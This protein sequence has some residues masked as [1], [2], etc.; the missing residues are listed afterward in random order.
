VWTVGTVASGNSA[1]LQ[2]VATVASIGTKSNVA[3]LTAADQPDTD[4]TPNNGIA[5]EDDQDS[6]D[7]TPLVADVSLTKTVSN[8]TPNVGDNVTFTITVANAGPDSATNLTVGDALP[9]GMTFVTDTA[10]QG[11]YNSGTGVWTVG[12]I[13]SGATATLQIVASVDSIG[14]KTNTAQVTAADQAD[15]DSTPN[16]SIAAEDDQD[17]AAVTPQVVDLSLTKTVSNAT[18]N[19]GNNVTFTITTNNAGPDAATNVTVAD[20]LPAGTTFVSSTP[21]QGSY[22]NGTGVWTVGT[23]ANGGNATLQIVASVDSIGTKTNTAQVSAADQADSD[24][25]PNNSVATEDDQAS[26]SLTPQVV[27]LSLTKTVSNATPNVGDN[28]TFTITTANAG[29]DAATNV[30]VTD[31]LPT[32]MT[33]VSSTPSLGTYTSTPGVWSIGTIPSGGN[34]TLQI[35]ATVAS[36]GTKTNTAQVRGADQA[37]VDSTPNNSVATEDDQASVSLTPRVA[38]LSLTKTVSNATPNVGANVTLRLRWRTRG[39]IPQRALR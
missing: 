37:D 3:E 34:A 27:D 21:S 31:L 22:N 4:S 36:I 26:V 9:A 6:V 18:P 30:S 17:D 32:G 1:T 15:S 7:V 5:A 39:R 24:S 16:N 38:D 19:V 12:T 25:T 29:P 20:T 13:A 2:I 28:V 10:S 11:T 14:T 35:V 8:A 33:F 23:I